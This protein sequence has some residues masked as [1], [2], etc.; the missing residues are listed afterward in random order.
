VG[1]LAVLMAF[2]LI[3]VG[4]FRLAWRHP[5]P[6][7]ANLALGLTLIICLQA[8]VNMAVAV[9]MLPTKGLALPF[10]SYG[11]SALLVNMAEIGILLS[12]AREARCGS[13]A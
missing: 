8:A 2:L 13:Y 4:G 3:A 1:T 5:E 9:G 12:V 11:G 7:G 10:V 6:Y